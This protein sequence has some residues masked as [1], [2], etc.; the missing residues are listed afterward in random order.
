MSGRIGHFVVSLAVVVIFLANI[1]STGLWFPDAP[2]HALNGVFYKDMIEEAGFLRPM[3]YAERYYVQY[4]KL[5]VGMY[6]PVFYTVEA[7][8]FKVFGIS[9]LVAKSTVLAFTLLG[10]NVFFLLCRLWFPAWLSVVGCFLLMLQ[11]STLFGQKN[12][13][14]EM[15]A[16]S[17]S[18]VAVYYLY[19]ATRRNSGW[20]LFLA[21][22]F[23]SLAFL[24]KQN[25][26]F[27]IAV[28][29]IWLI[30]GRKW[31]LV[32]C[33]YL[34]SGVLVGV[35]L[36]IPWA[37]I[38]LTIG[39]FY[40]TSFALQKYH[41][42]SNILYY[43]GHSSEIVSHAV[44][45]LNVLSLMLIMKLKG[46]DS[47]K[48][49]ILWGC[50]VLLF[51][52]IVEYREPRY[53]MFLIPPMIIL[54]L[55][56][57]W[58]LKSKVSLFSER[59]YVYPILMVVLVSVHLGDENVLGSRDI[60]GF[61]DVADFVVG[62]ADC[63]SVLYDGYF[64]GNFIFHMRRRDQDKRIF[65]FRA[66]KVIFSTKMLP[67][68]GYYQLI[69]GPSE[70]QGVLNCY[71]IK[72]IIQEERD[73]LATPG[74]RRLREWVKRPEFRLVQKFTVS[75][76]E[77]DVI[78]NFLVYEYLGYTKKPIRRI[79]LDMPMLGRKISVDVEGECAQRP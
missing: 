2:S 69:N 39:R 37:I 15:P 41:L 31:H 63:I 19:I 70:F 26:I 54:S 49:S 44:I 21:P 62:D 53:A 59:K 45:A 32:N 75:S 7:L 58:F 28:W 34:M 8:F 74:N 73:L 55:Q 36:L 67:K 57:I 10:V 16:L 60:R 27:L 29:L 65:V 1:S 77:L 18:I 48:L 11:P 20:T 71:G 13:M 50:S 72:Y 9:P 17:M 40:I 24:T 42:L 79:N 46:F 12:V 78:R 5:T 61:D 52:S 14:L 3:K 68:L 30:M 38:N 35:I 56:G 23:A 33:R 76:N 6:P 47:Y 51:L 22:I 64:N 25:N 43:F 66:S 4:P